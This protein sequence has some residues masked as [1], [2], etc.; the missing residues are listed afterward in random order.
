MKKSMENLEE[1]YVS[2]SEGKKVFYYVFWGCL[3]AT[4]LTVIAVCFPVIGSRKQEA[5]DV[6]EI[7][8]SIFAYLGEATKDEYDEIAEKIRHDLILGKYYAEDELEYLDYI[9][10]KTERCLAEPDGLP[11]QACLLDLN[12]GQTYALDIFEDGIE[13]S[14]VQVS[15]GYDEI[16]ET[17]LRIMSDLNT[18]TGT[19][20]IDGKRSI[21]SV[22]R[23][24][25]L[26]CDDCIRRMLKVN[27]NVLEPELILYNGAENEFYPIEGGETYLCGDYEIQVSYNEQGKYELE[28]KY[29]GGE[30]Y[31][32]KREE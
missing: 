25:T 1:V 28:V 17:W 14:G 16:S 8:D 18:G 5:E 31:D 21:V 19:A 20:V 30:V 23:M 13:Q 2:R 26:F 9:P 24:K 22:H 7:M 32:R 6:E 11:Y 29:L 15:W 27:E 12:T 4:M 10:N 3:M